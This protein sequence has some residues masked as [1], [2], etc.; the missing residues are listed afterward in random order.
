MDIEAHADDPREIIRLVR[1]WLNSNRDPGI[2]PRP[3]AK[4]INDDHVVHPR[5]DVAIVANLHLSH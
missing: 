2:S 5:I 3:A 4:S 1:G